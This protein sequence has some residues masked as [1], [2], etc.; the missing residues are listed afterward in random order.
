MFKQDAL[1]HFAVPR[2]ARARTDKD[3][4]VKNIA[5]TLG[6]TNNAVSQWGAII[7]EGAAEKLYRLTFKRILLHPEHYTCQDKL[8]ALELKKTFRNMR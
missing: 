6:I 8:N 1:N 5:E 3:M 7:P 4:A 2:E